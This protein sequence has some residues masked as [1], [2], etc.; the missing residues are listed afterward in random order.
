[1]L[2]LLSYYSTSNIYNH[3]MRD[4]DSESCA[5]CDLSLSNLKLNISTNSQ[6]NLPA[7]CSLDSIKNE[8]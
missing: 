7:A 1:M 5:V 8:C 4:W 6:G 3:L 2:Q